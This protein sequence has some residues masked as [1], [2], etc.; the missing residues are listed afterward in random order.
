MLDGW[1]SVAALRTNGKY[2]QHERHIVVALVDP[3]ISEPEAMPST[4]LVPLKTTKSLSAA[5]P[6]HSKQFGT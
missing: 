1:D 4:V 2:L 6:I 5:S 3:S